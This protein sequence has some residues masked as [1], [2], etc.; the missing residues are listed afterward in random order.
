MPLDIPSEIA[1]LRGMTVQQLAARHQEVFG[2]S[3]PS[4]HKE[5]LVRRI[6]WRLQALAEGDLSE[7]ARRRAAEL[8]RDADLRTRAPRERSRQ[9]P[10][11]K[12]PARCDARLPKPGTILV[13]CYRGRTLQVRVLAQGFE[14]ED[15]LYRTL[16]AV[17]KQI[18]GKHW[19][20]YHFF[21]LCDRKNQP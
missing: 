15:R 5:Y 16:T 13:R 19:N 9:T 12:A 8:V 4:R 11:A 20:G 21:G 10:A 14:Y 17:A 18:T 3:A 2:E 1:K 6:A 7:R